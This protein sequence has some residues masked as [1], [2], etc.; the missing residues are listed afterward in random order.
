MI[1]QYHGLSNQGAATGR[2]GMRV[3]AP[4]STFISKPAMPSADEP[5]QPAPVVEPIAEPVEE[6]VVEDAAPMESGGPADSVDGYSYAPDS[7]FRSYLDDNLASGVLG[8]VVGGP[9]VKAGT[10]VAMAAAMDVPS[11]MYGDVALSGLKPSPI[12][13]VNEMIN[14]PVK[15]FGVNK[16]ADAFEPH[17]SGFDREKQDKFNAMSVPGYE[18]SDDPVMNEALQMEDPTEAFSEDEVATMMAANE[19]VNQMK[20][21]TRGVGTQ[22]ISGLA[23]ATPFKE[24]TLQIWDDVA[25]PEYLKRLQEAGQVSGGNNI[26]GLSEQET[27]DTFRNYGYDDR[28]IGMAPSGGTMRSTPVAPTN[29]ASAKS[30]LEAA[31]AISRATDPAMAG[32]DMYG[33]DGNGGGV[34]GGGAANGGGRAGNAGTSDASGGM[35]GY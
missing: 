6:S 18:Y 15:A 25:V 12:G 8:D 14:L 24:D 35:G 30:A 4:V 26:P 3:T 16:V 5:A 33:R 32:R 29:E 28:S 23:E 10:N 34:G 20:Q 31:M 13:I 21:M 7:E 22:A 1:T 9:A 2:K 17:M 27:H 19:A 11:N